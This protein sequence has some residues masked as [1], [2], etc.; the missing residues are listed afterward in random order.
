MGVCLT[1]L[2]PSYWPRKIWKMSGHPRLRLWLE[3]GIGG[4]WEEQPFRFWVPCANP[5]TN[6]AE[7]SIP[8]PH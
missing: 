8:N 4:S 1:Q 7:A 6:R 2:T 5:M 3:E